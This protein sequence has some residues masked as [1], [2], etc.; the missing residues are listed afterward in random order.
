VIPKQIKKLQR[1]A[2]RL[3]VRQIAPNTMIVA[4]R[5]NPVF[6]YVVT[7][8][9]EASGAIQARCTCDWARHGGIACTHVLAA[10]TH[11][12][13]RRQRD[14]SFWLDHEAA[15]RQHQ[16]ILRLGDDSSP[17]FITTRQKSSA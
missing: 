3:I 9:R 10:L 5:T 15:L 7:V 4:S 14:I 12:A 11:L 13:E 1:R 2:R 17:V 16:R 6:Q 8:H